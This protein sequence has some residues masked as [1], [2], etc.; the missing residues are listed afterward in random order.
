MKN[1]PFVANH[2]DN[3]HCVNAVYRMIHQ[4]YLGTDLS[5]SQI[6]KISHAHKG[7]GTWTFPMETYLAKKGIHVCNIEPVDYRKLYAEGVDY[8]FEVMGEKM[9]N[10]F[11]HRSNISHVL[12]Y[13]PE[14]IR[15]VK[16]ETRRS[17]MNDIIKLLQEGCLVAA[18]INMSIMNKTPGFD[19]HVVLLY[20]YADGKIIFHDPGLPPVEGRTITPEIFK[21]CF[22]FAGA[23]GAITYFSK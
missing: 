23:N 8:L 11:I 6:D 20:D 22:R 2:K 3:Q 5:W 9:A 13:I 15:S 21:E 14:Y 7:K 10:Y 16:H 4:Y 18:E 17:S 12:Q 1:V 19:M